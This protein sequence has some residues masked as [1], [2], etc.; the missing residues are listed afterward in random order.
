MRKDLENTDRLTFL[1]FFCSL[2][3]CFSPLL[4]LLVFKK[5]LT[6]ERT[7]QIILFHSLLCSHFLSPDFLLA[8]ELVAA[9]GYVAYICRSSM[10]CFNCIIIT[11]L[12]ERASGNSPVSFCSFSQSVSLHCR[13]G[14][15]VGSLRHLDSRV[16]VASASASSHRLTGGRQGGWD[17]GGGGV[18]LLYL[19]LLMLLVV[20]V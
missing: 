8:V 16:A 12:G 14:V 15:R 2:L 6:A 5:L 10:V 18:A 13:L 3:L 4:A 9:C 20:L 1:F 11:N 17:P 7:L 19:L